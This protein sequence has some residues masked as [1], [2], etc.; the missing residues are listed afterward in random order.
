M[1]RVIESHNRITDY[2]TRYAQLAEP[3]E[4]SRGK[5]RYHFSSNGTRRVFFILEGDFLLKLQSENKMLNILSAPFVM[6]VSPSLDEPPLYLERV[7]Y[8]KVSYINYDF[9]W[10]TVLK[11]GLLSDVMMIMSEQYSDLMDY[12]MLSKS[13]SYDQ[14]LS[15]IERWQK[16]PPHLKRRFSALH[17]IEHSSYLSKSSISRVLKELKDSGG[18]TLERGRF[19][20]DDVFKR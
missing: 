14:V 6:G 12:I 18:L 5:R 11:E 1:H 10:E 4:I 2:F 13:N 3:N 9:F 8:G 20:H 17:L 19:N 16:I 7:D 15:L